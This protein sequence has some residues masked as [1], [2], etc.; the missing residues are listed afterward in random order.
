MLE[1]SMHG[2]IGHNQ[3]KRI[4]LGDIDGMREAIL[5]NRARS[6]EDYDKDPYIHRVDRKHCDYMSLL[7]KWERKVQDYIWQLK[8]AG[9]RVVYADICGRTTAVERGADISYG[10]SL[11]ASEMTRIV[12]PKQDILVDGDLFRMRDFYSF[13]ALMRDKG[14]RPAFVTFNPMA[15]LQSY[16]PSESDKYINTRL[17][18]RVTWQ[19]LANNLRHLLEVVRPGGYVY[20]DRPF[21]LAGTDTIDWLLKKELKDYQ[22][23]MWMKEF[24]KGKQCSVMVDR[25]ISGL[26]FLLHKRNQRRK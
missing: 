26:K 10:F 24:C 15:G 14:D 20:L 12:H 16:T 4:A 22:S 6:A 5:W 2:G 3:P 13:L 7:P 9:Q 23:A 11:H 18:P 19:R 8:Q 1:S 17:H 21:Q 25:D